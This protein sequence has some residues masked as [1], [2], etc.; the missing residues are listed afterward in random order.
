MFG[1]YLYLKP[2]CKKHEIEKIELKEKFPPYEILKASLRE[3][4]WLGFMPFGPKYIFEAIYDDEFLMRE[5]DPITTVEI[6]R[7]ILCGPVTI[8]RNQPNDEGE[9]QSTGLSAIECDYLINNLNLREG[10][11]PFPTTGFEVVTFENREDLFKA[12]KER[13]MF[14]ER[15]NQNNWG[16]EQ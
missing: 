1:Y 15:E 2:G 6:N 13:R 5:G 7:H 14:A 8:W 9:I 12:S 10:R 16:G 4:R 3:D 11:G